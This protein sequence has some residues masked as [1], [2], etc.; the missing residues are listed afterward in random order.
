[1]SERIKSSTDKGLSAEQR[2]RIR[3]RLIPAV[4]LTAALAGA[5]IDEGVHYL[6]DTREIV[7]TTEAVGNHGTPI[8]TVR[9]AVERIEREKHIS[10]DTIEPGDIVHAGQEVGG[11]LQEATGETAVQPTDVIEVTVS[12]S[13]LER[14]LGR[15][16]VSAD[17]APEEK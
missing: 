11:E 10:P 7:T 17:L 8:D 3:N 12:Q 1:M 4:A 5:G 2:R 16:H 13:G 15:Y 9:A 6:A 14:I